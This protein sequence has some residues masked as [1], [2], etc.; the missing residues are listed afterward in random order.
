MPKALLLEDIP[1]LII[2]RRRRRLEKLD[3]DDDDETGPS[4]ESAAQQ[5]ATNRV[6]QLLKPRLNAIGLNIR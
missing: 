3:D 5:L 2:K 4:M 6:H 1:P